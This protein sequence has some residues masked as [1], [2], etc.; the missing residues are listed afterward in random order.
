[1]AKFWVKLY[2]IYFQLK[3]ICI[4][5]GNRQITG[6]VRGPEAEDFP[7]FLLSP[8]NRYC[9]VFVQSKNCAARKTAVAS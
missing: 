5:H 6:S 4:L 8:S 9:G 1:M 3:I 2:A 7:D